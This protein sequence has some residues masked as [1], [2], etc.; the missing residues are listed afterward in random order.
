[1]PRNSS[2]T[3]AA[4]MVG[5]AA[6]SHPTKGGSTMTSLI[7]AVL[8][9]VA[10]E[11]G[12][13]NADKNAAHVRSITVVGNGEASA[14]PDTAEIQIGVVTQAATAGEAL[15]ANNASMGRLQK[16]LA[17]RGIAE[18]DVQTSNF[19]VAPQYQQTRQAD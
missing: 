16:S 15:S 6:S 5:F 3:I 7:L 17:G 11:G 8:A 10:Q 1:M 13:I 18:K 12:A 9:S 14:K 4:C 19:S 2:S